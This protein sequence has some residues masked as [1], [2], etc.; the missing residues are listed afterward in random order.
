MNTSVDNLFKIP[1]FDEALQFIRAL[2]QI[3]TI[4][5]FGSRARGSDAADSDL[6]ICVVFNTLDRRPIV[7]M[8]DLHSALS[9]ILMM[10]VDVLVYEKQRFQERCDA[11]ASF[12][13]TVVSEGVAV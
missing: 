1:H 4:Y 2:G 5:V 13:R 11:G 12:E 10:P 9:R 3:E 8:R 7:V 6:D